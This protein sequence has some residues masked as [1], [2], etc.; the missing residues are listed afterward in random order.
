MS[1]VP[2]ARSVPHNKW[3]NIMNISTLPALAA[4][5]VAA[6][7]AGCLQQQSVRDAASGCVADAAKPL[8]M[9]SIDASERLTARQQDLLKHVTTRAWG[10]V[11]P[12]AEFR[13]YVLNGRPAEVVPMLRLCR[14]PALSALDGPRTRAFAEH[15][16]RQAANDNAVAKLTE[17][18]AAGGDIGAQAKGSRI[19]EHLAAVPRLGEGP[20]TSRHLIIFSD[21]IQLSPS[22]RTNAALPA[23]GLNLAGHRLHVV[24]LG[25]GASLHSGWQRLLS[26][27]GADVSVSVE[28]L[29]PELAR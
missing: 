3:G 23:D 6:G 21:M 8:H 17:E 14:Q 16:A 4:I 10:Q 20:Y 19:Y 2:A 29:P 22:I 25:D 9:L 28:G 11:P 24:L 13:V 5:S 27:S 18:I 26:N 1:S 12:N 15:S 7:L